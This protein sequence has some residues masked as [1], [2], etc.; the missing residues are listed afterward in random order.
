MVSGLSGLVVLVFEKKALKIS[1]IPCHV[2]WYMPAISALG[3]LR[4]KDIKF[5]ASLG[6]ID[7]KTLPQN[8]NKST[9]IVY[10]TKMSFYTPV[11]CLL[12]ASSV[13][14]LEYF[15]FALSLFSLPTLGGNL[16]TTFT[17]LLSPNTP[18][19]PTFR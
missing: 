19:V 10:F 17:S 1:T 6:Y 13:T 3:R 18:V 4:P 11:S 12:L 7:S 9:F 2:W 15:H 14:S 5:K 8:N 16:W